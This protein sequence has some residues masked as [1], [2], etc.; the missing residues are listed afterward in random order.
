MGQIS[1]AV[2]ISGGGTNLQAMIDHIEKGAIPGKIEV[3]I[4]SR[5]D[6]YGLVRAKKHGIEGIY[7]GKKNYPDL[8]EREN[9]ILAVLEEK[10]VD[11][12]VLAGYMSIFGEKLVEKYRNR[13]INVHPALIPSFCGKGFY[14]ER[15]HQA[16]LDYG[17]KVTGATVHFVDEGTD[18]GPV[19][20]QKAVEVKDEDTVQTLAKRVLEIEHE[21]LPK[22]IQ[23]FAEGKLVIE[24]RKVRIIR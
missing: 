1:M 9:K 20:L 8:E 23:L 16:V 7:I 24:G 15:I 21:L 10:K 14:G 13:I 2:F 12:I 5:E 17:V 4:S 18:T 22:A 11:L 6:A 3:V 19:I